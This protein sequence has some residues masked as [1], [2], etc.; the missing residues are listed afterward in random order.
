MDIF[1]I[2]KLFKIK[3]TKTGLGLKK[4][5]MRLLVFVTGLLLDYGF[6]SYPPLLPMVSYQ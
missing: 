2:Y 4:K 1:L 5:T 3:K 6:P